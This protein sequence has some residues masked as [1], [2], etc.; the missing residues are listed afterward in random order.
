MSDLIIG[1]LIGAG[2]GVLFSGA[3]FQGRV[4]GKEHNLAGEFSQELLIACWVGLAVCALVLIGLATNSTN[5][6]AIAIGAFPAAL[7][8]WLYLS[9][10]VDEHRRFPAAAGIAAAAITCGSLAF[11]F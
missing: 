10:W 8:L 9:K 1:A 6:G 11:L 7:T 3:A 5:P 2:M 4:K